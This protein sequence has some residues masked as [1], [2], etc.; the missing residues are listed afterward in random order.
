VPWT[1]GY[2][3]GAYYLCFLNSIPDA[4]LLSDDRTQLL[5]DNEAGLQ[6]FKTIEAGF[7]AKFFDPNIDPTID[8]Y[9]TGKMFN[10]KQTA[11][12]INFAEL[13]GYAVG[14]DPTNFPSELQPDEVGATILPGITSG[15]TGSINGFEGF[16]LNKYGK[17]KEAT[18]SFLRYLTG[19]EF[20]KTM[21]LG[22]TL[23]SSRTSVLNDS[24]VEAAYPI[25]EVLARQGQ[26]NLDRYA[27][28]YDW[29]PPFSASFAKLYRGEIGAEQ[30]HEETV[31]G[32]QTI[33]TDYLAG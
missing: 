33:I 18:L 13:W 16:G 32:I 5:F 30:A 25:G 28:P 26:S 4:K 19:P 17:Q 12:Q 14:G 2:G 1:V 8:D 10:A 20:Q 29:T 11:S 7:K 3:P 22:K 15:N 21:N 23:P 9:G 24:E 6:A 31:A 27:A